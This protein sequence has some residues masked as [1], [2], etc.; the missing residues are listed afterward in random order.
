VIW[1]L[2][3]GCT[4]AFDQTRKDLDDFRLVAMGAHDGALDTLVWSG[5]GAFHA[6]APTLAWTIDGQETT[7]APD[8]PFSAD[9]RVEDAAGDHE[10][11]RLDVDADATVPV[12]T[13]ITREV[14]GATASIALEGPADGMYTRWMGTSGT[15]TETGPDAA[16]WEADEDGIATL[17][18]LTLDGHGGNTWTWIDVETGPTVPTL[19]VDGRLLVIDGTAPQI[20]G[21]D[22]WYLATLSA[23]DTLA[24][25]VL[26]DVVPGDGTGGDVVCG[27]DPFAIAALADGRCGRDEA[28]G[29]RVALFGRITP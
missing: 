20:T 28:A 6:T 19:A 8:A 29:A 1:L 23:A 11:G 10:D 14:D 5:E 4:P 9:L 12:V 22:G 3:T 7:T 26:S 27:L 21:E 16:D 17:V 25:Y 13:G 24:G 15:F 18:A 2:L